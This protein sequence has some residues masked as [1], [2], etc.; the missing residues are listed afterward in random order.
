MS[1]EGFLFKYIWRVAEYGRGAVN[2]GEK[3]VPPVVRLYFAEDSL[4][5]ATWLLR[6]CVCWCGKGRCRVV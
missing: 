2:D 6:E 5:V 1:K 4:G 3:S